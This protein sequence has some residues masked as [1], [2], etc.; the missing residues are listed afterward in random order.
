MLCG[1]LDK[2]AT[3]RGM[4]ISLLCYNLNIL[5]KN[6][7]LIFLLCI[8]SFR[9]S[10]G[11]T[12][13]L[14]NGNVLTAKDII[15]LKGSLKFSRPLGYG[16]GDINDCI[17][18]KDDVI[19]ISYDTP[20]SPKLINGSYIDGFVLG[21]Q[22]ARQLHSTFLFVIPGIIGGAS[23]ILWFPTWVWAAYLDNPTPIGSETITSSEPLDGYEAG[24][25]QTARSMNGDTVLVSAGA[26]FLG[27]LA[28]YCYGLSQVVMR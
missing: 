17:L 12:I 21:A 7:I 20:R 10:L 22:S 26:G 11:E 18:S 16:F 28:L 19:G 15:F 5:L 14:K 2:L 24:Y 3:W 13:L 23:M 9:I 4:G 8:F 25:R 27:L 1:Q 6:S